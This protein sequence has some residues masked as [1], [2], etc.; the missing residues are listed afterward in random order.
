MT[1]CLP[2]GLQNVLKDVERRFGAVVMVST[3]EL[4]TDNHGRGSVRHRL[5]SACQAADFKVKGDRKA[6]VAYLRSRSEIAGVNSYG[7]NGVIHIDHAEP[8]QIAQR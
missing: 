4:H 7:N 8:R 6:V 3:T 1:D 2:T 5:H